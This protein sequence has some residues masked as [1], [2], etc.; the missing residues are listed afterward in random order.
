MLTV[1]LEMS[2]PTITYLIM[3][4]VPANP[5]QNIQHDT[6]GSYLQEL[7]PIHQLNQEQDDI[8]GHGAVTVS[9]DLFQTQFWINSL[10]GL[11]MSVRWSLGAPIGWTA[12]FGH[13][14]CH[15]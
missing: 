8:I 2:C 1:Y 15:I 3:Q 6:T 5:T 14:I 12:H 11:N 13:Q 9:C 10:S 7:L 4:T